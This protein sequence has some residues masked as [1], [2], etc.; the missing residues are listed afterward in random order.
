MG[1]TD[2]R[3]RQIKDPATKDPK[4][5]K[6]PKKPKITGMDVFTPSLPP[7]TASR[8]LSLARSLPGLLRSRVFRT[9]ASI[10]GL[11][12]DEQLDHLQRPLR[13]WLL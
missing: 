10:S 7:H 11:V 8:S 2:G 5:P 9:R 4:K 12:G 13:R 3:K 1:E 6:S